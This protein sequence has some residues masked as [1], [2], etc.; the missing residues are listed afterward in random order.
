MRKPDRMPPGRTAT[1]AAALLFTLTL[2]SC[3]SEETSAPEPVDRPWA[4]P[5]YTVLQ[6]TDHGVG[7]LLPSATKS[8][9]AAVIHHWLDTNADG[10]QSA[11][12]QVVRTRD[13]N[14]IV[15]RAEYYRDAKTAERMTDGRLV[16]DSWPHTAVNCPDPG[17]P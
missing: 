3:G 4:G 6:D 15:C 13:A 7:L 1:T 8:L 14:L 16:A 11:I 17:G 12:V 9:A 5:P 10:R 2:V